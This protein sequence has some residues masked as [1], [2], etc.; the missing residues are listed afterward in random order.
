M[1]SSKPD[2]WENLNACINIQI[3]SLKSRQK[4]KEGALKQ[5]GT[6]QGADSNYQSRNSK[7]MA[8]H[9]CLKGIIWAWI[10]KKKKCNYLVKMKSSSFKRSM[11]GP[12]GKHRWL[13][14]NSAQTQPHAA[15]SLK[16]LRLPRMEA[17]QTC[18]GGE[19][20]AAGGAEMNEKA[21]DEKGQLLE[22]LVVTSGTEPETTTLL[23]HLLRHYN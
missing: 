5:S 20:K 6:Q 13:K 19:R 3:G 15:P 12:A 10:K 4:N 1:L 21:Q 23:S 14:P 17:S 11:R 2:L 8:F 7:K 16:R 9:G 18:Q 22:T